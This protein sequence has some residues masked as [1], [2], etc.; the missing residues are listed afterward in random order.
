M[1]L[2]KEVHAESWLVQLDT[3]TKKRVHHWVIAC[4]CELNGIPTVAHLN[5]LPLGPYSMPLGMDCLYHHRTKV[6]Y[7]DKV[8]ECLYDNGEN[9]IL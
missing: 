4:A 5:V 2:R 1:W 7:Y 6:Y 9:I 3:G 8:I